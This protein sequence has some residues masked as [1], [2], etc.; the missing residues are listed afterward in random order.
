MTNKISSYSERSLVVFIE[1]LSSDRCIEELHHPTVTEDDWVWIR[2]YATSL[3]LGITSKCNSDCRLCFMKNCIYDEMDIP[4]ISDILKKAGKNKKV[5]LWGGE[6][7]TRKDLPKIIKLVKKSGN[8]PVVYTNGLKFADVNYVKTLKK[9]GL[10]AVIFSFDGFRED[11]YKVL[12]RDENHLELKKKALENLRRL[13]L[14]T[15][16]SMTV[17]RDLNEDQIIPILDF[18]V[19]NNDFIK[20]LSIYT[21]VK[22][23]RNEFGDFK[24]ISPNQIMKIIEKEKQDIKREYF[25]QL[26][27]LMNSMNRLFSKIGINSSKRRVMPD[28]LY[29]VEDNELSEAIKLEDLISMNEILDKKQYL[30]ILKYVLKYRNLISIYIKSKFKPAIFEIEIGKRNYLN[31]YISFPSNDHSVRKDCVS[32][33]KKDDLTKRAMDPS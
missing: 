29:I 23:G 13:N 4:Y 3:L 1:G 2:K 17:L 32:L 10:E 8:L 24:V 26:K 12:R 16:I 20:S 5:I 15:H 22:F 21:A 30:R 14:Q 33:K 9:A 27:R 19:M 18:C 25:I 7:T 28:G 31:L 6:P 11:I